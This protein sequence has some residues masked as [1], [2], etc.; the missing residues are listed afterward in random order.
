MSKVAISQKD[1]ENRLLIKHNGSIKMN[2]YSNISS[3]SDFECV[4]CGYKWKAIAKSVITNGNGCSE[5]SKINLRNKYSYSFEY[6]KEYIESKGFKLHSKEYIN[7]KQ[8]LILECPEGHIL[9]KCFDSFRDR[10]NCTRCQ[11][12][13][14]NLSKRIPYEILIQYLKEDNFEFIE[15]PEEYLNRNSLIT[16]KCI[17]GHINTMKIRE[18]LKNRNCQTCTW[19]NQS[20]SQRGCKG[21]NWQGGKTEIKNG[22]KALMSQWKKESM[23][24]CNYKCVITKGWFDDIHHL[25]SF[26]QILNDSIKELNFQLKNSF[27]DYISDE[28]EKLYNQVLLNHYKHP[29]GVCLTKNVHKLFHKYYGNRNN[30]PEQFYEFQEKIKN[31]EIKIAS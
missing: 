16:Y 7:S 11:Q 25:Y 10:P 12:I 14:N 1:A 19:I 18:Y 21:N 5:C 20:E 15:F 17:K 28:L 26:N 24:N 30:T 2:S 13:K 31:G 8:D 3:Y 27:G 29:L 9:P 6:I 4:I 22:L 23:I